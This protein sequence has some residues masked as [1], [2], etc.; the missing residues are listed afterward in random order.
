MTVP[1]IPPLCYMCEYYVP[2]MDPENRM[3]R[4]VCRAFPDGIPDEIMNGGYDHRQPLFDENIL[5]KLS[6][7]YTAEDLKEWERAALDLEK[8]DLLSRV[9]EME[10]DDEAP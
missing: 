9:D 2:G 7:N 10:A 8:Q 6:K 1:A 4:P 3:N 5:F